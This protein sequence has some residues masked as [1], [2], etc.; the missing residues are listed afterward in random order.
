MARLRILV[1]LAGLFLLSTPS[2]SSSSSSSSS[3][4]P[5]TDP[6]LCN[7][8]TVGPRPE[9]FVFQVDAANWAY[10]P[11]DIVTTIAAFVNPIPLD[12]VC[13]AH[14]HNVRVVGSA[15]YPKEQLQNTSYVETFIAQ[16]QAF[17]E[18]NYLDG[19][20]FDFEDPLN[21]TADAAALTQVISATTSAMKAAYGSEFQMSVDVAWSPNNIDGRA[22]DYAGIAAAVDYVFAM[23][24]DMRS[25][26]FGA[27][28]ASANCPFPGFVEGLL[29][30]TNLGIPA[31]K[32][33]SGIPW[34]GYEYPCLNTPNPATGDVCNIPSVPFR[35]VNCSDAAGGEVCYSGVMSLLRNNATI[36]STWNASLGSPF[37]NYVDSSSGST[38]QVW[39]DD[40]RSLSLRYAY[41]KAQGYGGVGMWNV[42]CVDYTSTD[43]L[44]VADTKGMWDAIAQFARP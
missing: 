43:P 44:V 20:N 3:P 1:A 23:S 26:I 16:M 36:P 11:Y 32:I 34:Y 13:Y 22:Y 4:C 40:P 39:Y 9:V 37:F 10:Y 33:I 15:P 19:L 24:Y 5:C 38:V 17:V 7:R 35:G 27:C 30:F 28:I 12:M 2:A 14:A 8:V 18:A 29:N 6:N 41:A 21:T 42:D 25:Q 31:S